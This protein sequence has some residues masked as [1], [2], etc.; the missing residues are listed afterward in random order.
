MVIERYILKANEYFA[1][2][3]EPIEH[4][5]HSNQQGGLDLYIEVLN[6]QS[7]EHCFKKLYKNKKGLYFKH[8]GYPPSYL[9][10]FIKEVAYIP[11]QIYRI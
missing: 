9:S 3:K 5:Q 7:S 8:T 1:I 2:L 6:L 10:D 11:Y 4:K